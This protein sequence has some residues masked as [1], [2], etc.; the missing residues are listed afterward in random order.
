MSKK[1][2][3]EEE[4]TG[5][6]VPKTLPEVDQEVD[7]GL[8]EVQRMYL[9]KHP[10]RPHGGYA[11]PINPNPVMTRRG[12]KY[13]DKLADLTAEQRSARL[14]EWKKSRMRRRQEERESQMIGDPSYLVEERD[15]TEDSKEVQKTAAKRRKKGGK[16]KGRDVMKLSG[17]TIRKFL[18]EDKWGGLCAKVKE[19]QD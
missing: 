10:D 14:E 17:G 16:G 9:E 7:P 6:K 5:Q 3:P 13:V 1:S 8:A 4:D 2:K 19:Y 11:F 15:I 12:S 18:T